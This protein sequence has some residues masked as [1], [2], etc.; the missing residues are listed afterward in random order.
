MSIFSRKKALFSSILALALCFSTLLGTTYAWFTDGST[1]GDNTVVGGNFDLE[2]QYTLDGESWNDLDGAED[3]F[4][5][6]LFEPGH[7]EVV[8][9][10]IENKG[11]L[12]MMYK[13]DLNVVKETAGLSKGGDVI[14]LSELLTVSTLTIEAA[15][16]DPVFG[17]DIAAMTL[18]KAFES[19]NAIAWSEAATLNE[20]AALELDKPLYSG[21]TQYLF[22][23]LDMPDTVGEKANHNGVNVPSIDLGVS[24]LATQ[25]PF[26]NDSFGNDYDADA[27]YP[28]T[29]DTWDG[30][31]N[32]EWYTANPDATTF[33]LGSAEDLAGLSA[34]VSG[35]VPAAYSGGMEQL[36]ISFEGK[37]FELTNDVDLYL[38][39][40]NG[41]RVNFDP[42]G[43]S[44]N[45]Q[46]FKGV[47]DGKG[48]TISNMYV[49][50]DLGAWQYEGEYYSLFAYTDGATI[51]NVNIDGAYLSSGRNEAACI[52]GNAV[53]TTFENINI[54][55]STLIAYN[56]SA[57]GIAAECYGT[58][59]FNNITV[60]D[61][62]VVG[63]LWGTYDV[64]LGGIVGMVKSDAN[65]TFK[66][67]TVACKLDA[68]NDVASN[69]QYWLYRYS[70]MLIGQ[71]DGVDGVADPTGYV[72][73]ENVK[74]IYGDWV[75]YHYCEDADLGAGSYNGPGEYKYGRVEAGTGT[76]GIDLDS[77]N[78]AEDESHNVLIVFDQ[79]FGGGQGVR[80]LTTYEGVEVTYPSAE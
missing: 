58:C 72:T 54:S 39:D 46:A 49:Q 41:N 38:E 24:V 63:P 18:E 34:L 64:R 57:G 70:G 62:T 37:T 33:T 77:C 14:K 6:G 65:V 60:D 76:D 79:L 47:F 68:I 40:E 50:N 25:F 75:N 19:E 51:K 16:V 5:M 27:E 35:D 78:H 15:G 23:K 74:V 8:A 13:A 31:V 44:S 12:A 59:S 29:T 3:L 61:K 48:H 36:P 11:S 20:G 9:L 45:G 30:T 66:D 67:I 69:Y 10:K 17:F 32:I 55:N 80:G 52:A 43:H 7:T 2:V 71:V 22:V 53:N 26:E 56:N 4:Q 42:I 28:A 21:K 73:C 1:S